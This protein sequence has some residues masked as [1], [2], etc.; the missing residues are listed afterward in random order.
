MAKLL[1][2]LAYLGILTFAGI[3]LAGSP[4]QDRLLKTGITKPEMPW[5]DAPGLFGSGLGNGTQVDGGASAILKKKNGSGTGTGT[6]FTKP[7]S[8]SGAGNGSGAQ[9][10]SGGTPGSPGEMMTTS[11]PG[12]GGVQ[13]LPLFYPMCLFIDSMYSSEEGSKTVKGL[14]DDAAA[15]GVALVVFPFTLKPG[16][17]ESPDFINSA[18]QKMCNIPQAGIAPAASTSSCVSWPLSAD[19]MCVSDPLP[20][21]YSG[22]VAG[23]AEL[24]AAR[25]KT[26]IPEDQKAE[27]EARLKEHLGSS[28]VKVGGGVAVSIEDAGSCDSG[29]VGHEALGHSQFGHPNGQSSG[30]AIGLS[31]SGGGGSGWTE[32]GCSAMRKN[33]FGNDGRW[34]YDPSRETYYTK[35][36]NPEAWKDLM[37]PEPIFKQQKQVAQQA[38]PPQITTPP[39]QRITMSD[40]PKAQNPSVPPAQPQKGKAQMEDGLEGRHRKLGSALATL[41]GG[42]GEET[43]DGA[44][45][46]EKP[47]KFSASPKAPP[48]YPPKNP[49]PRI[50]FD[51]AAPKGRSIKGGGATVTSADAPPSETYGESSDGAPGDAGPSGS[52]GAS[53]SP[54]AS[55]GSATGSGATLGYDDNAPKGGLNAGSFYGGR[56]PASLGSDAGNRTGGVVRAGTG[57]W[58]SSQTDEEEFFEEV[59]EDGEPS[60]RKKKQLRRRGPFDREPAAI[61]S[62]R[63][64]PVQ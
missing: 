1:K 6:E 20:P 52:Q 29:T 33:A 46:L 2:I 43:V 7:G 25:V 40:A 28:D 21:N 58:R 27:V 31:Q 23:C 54:P 14:V 16:Y 17:P 4:A 57:S 11:T 35:P 24:R 38:Q 12:G 15:C 37:N 61:R 30:H 34:T 5:V 45:E 9:T 18:Q 49:G 59:G 26:E 48:N 36:K 51:D 53:M 22:Q 64:E 60:P 3:S 44:P 56:G 8:A 50:G 39:G 19:K 32:E 42:K 41:L 55:Y 10:R 63:R 13:K 47:S 62:K